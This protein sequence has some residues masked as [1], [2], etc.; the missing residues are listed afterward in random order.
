MKGS[1]RECLSFPLSE[2]IFRPGASI[3]IHVRR[4]SRAASDE[5]AV[6]TYLLGINRTFHVRRCRLGEIPAVL[7]ADPANVTI[8]RGH[9]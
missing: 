1:T 3:G 4:R 5:L 6:L 7:E 2:H 8:L 9:A